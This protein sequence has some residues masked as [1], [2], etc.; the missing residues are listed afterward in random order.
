MKQE[1]HRQAPRLK[2]R[3]EWVPG[4]NKKKG[5][6]P[7]EYNAVPRLLWKK[8]NEKIPNKQG[9]ARQI[10]LFLAV[11]N[12]TGSFAVVQLYMLE[13]LQITKSVYYNARKYLIEHCL[14]EYNRQTNELVVNF[15]VLYMP[16]KEYEELVRKRPPITEEEC[17]M[18]P[19]DE[20]DP[21]WE[22]WI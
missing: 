20:D 2:A 9:A 10:L 21:N 6:R 5:F 16:Q 4:Y 13:F 12:T 17:E 3:G 14:L 19:M 22:D 8:I 1:Y 11:Q 7:G 15:D 18:I